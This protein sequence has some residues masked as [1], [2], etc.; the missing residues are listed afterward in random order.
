MKRID[1]MLTSA[2]VKIL[3]IGAS[4]TLGS[5]VAEALRERHEVIG[6]SRQ[7][8]NAVDITAPD[9]IRALY[10]AVG[11]VDAVASAAG[12]VPFR[13][14]P[15]LTRDDF[16][17]GA[18]NKLLGQIEIVRQGIDYVNDGGSFTLITG[19]LARE[20]VRGGCIAS[21]A[22]GGLESFVMAAAV[23][24][25]R[26]IRINAVSPT[27]F[28]E[29]MAHY[30]SVFAGFASVPVA[31]AAQAFVKSVEGAASGQVFRVG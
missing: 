18:R 21:L 6:A 5:A 8:A 7:G 19:V 15:A 28:T 27:V 14:L 10:A 9:S 29:S 22:N 24:M 11:R 23:E 4:G 13:P 17:A 30:G 12:G 20:P 2:F 31:A 25:P 1:A 3:L 16:E 26:G